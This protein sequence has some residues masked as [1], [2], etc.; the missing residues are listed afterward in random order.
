MVFR[1][2]S[3]LMFSALVGYFL[4]LLTF[5]GSKGTFLDILASVVH[6]EMMLINK[7]RHVTL[8]M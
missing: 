7:K 3:S 4:N 1:G 6:I 5:D 8:E 2:K